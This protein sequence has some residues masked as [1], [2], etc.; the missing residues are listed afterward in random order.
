[1]GI[2]AALR[3]EDPGATLSDAQSINRDLAL[4]LNRDIGVT[5]KDPSPDVGLKASIGNRFDFNDDWSLG[6]IAGTTYNTGWREA[7]RQST[8]HRFPD[9]RIDTDTESNRFVN[10]SGTLN[11]GL[12][13]TE[14]HE[15]STTTLFL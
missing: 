2:L 4:A 3:R 1:Q 9:R 14:D 6:F 7:I 11:L 13:F 10:L 5:E 8:N 15:I 12:S